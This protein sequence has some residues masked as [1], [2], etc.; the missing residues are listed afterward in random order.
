M[1]A[2][3]FKGVLEVTK[4]LLGSSGWLLIGLRL[5]WVVAKSF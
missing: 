4:E 5:F 1:V 3:A 2:K